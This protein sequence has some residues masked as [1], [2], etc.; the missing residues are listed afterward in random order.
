MP[1]ALTVAV[2]L[3]YNQWR[4]GAPLEFG[5]SESFDRSPLVGL[6]GFLLS[7][8]RSLF[9]F[10]PPLV[11]LVWSVPA[12][13]RR[14]GIWG[15]IL[16]SLG[17]LS[18]LVYSTWPVFWGGPV[19]GPRYLLP[20]LPLLVL[21]LAPTVESAWASKGWQRWAL[22]ALSFLGVAIQLPGV[23]WNSLPATQVLGQRY[24]LW[25]LRPRGEWLDVAWLREGNLVPLLLAVGL[26]LLALLTLRWPRRDLLTGATFTA[27]ISSLLMLGWLGQSDLGYQNHPAYDSV[28]TQVAARGQRGDALLLNPAPYQEPIAQL[29][30]FMNEPSVTIPLYALYREP[31]EEATVTA[32]RVIRLLNEYERL[33]LLTAGVGPGDPNSTAEQLLAQQAPLVDTAWLE[34][35]YRLTLFEHARPPIASGEVE[36]TLGDTVMLEQWAVAEGVTPGM[37]QLTF[38]WRPLISLEELSLHTFAQLLDE[39]GQLISGWDS[40]PQAGFAPLVWQ[41]GERFEE[42]ITL[43]LPSGAPRSLRLIVGM[44]DSTT[45]KRLQRADG[46]EFVE[47][48]MFDWPD[49]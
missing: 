30:W 44:Y 12:F 10:A 22:A 48:L 15:W 42:H 29:L 24:P 46:A 27:V 18:L 25:L 9:L 35:G 37:L 20:M 6:G 11:A 39:Q 2:L 41:P 19:W 32:E 5:Y 1:L 31:R 47:L 34:E 16:L 13:L 40:V 7:L 3:A 33:W 36:V 4:F 14:H 49:Q 21:L 28:M 43:R 23:L 45:G 17:L 26:M 8:D 38:Q